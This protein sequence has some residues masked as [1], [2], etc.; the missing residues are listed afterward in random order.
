[1]EEEDPDTRMDELEQE[2]EDLRETLFDRMRHVS[3]LEHK[4]A[5]TEQNIAVLRSAL[6]QYETVITEIQGWNS[7]MSE[8]KETILAA[9]KKIQDLSE[10]LRLLLEQAECRCK[11][12]SDLRL[13]DEL[14]NLKVSDAVPD[15]VNIT[16]SEIESVLSSNIPPVVVADHP[17]RP[18]RKWLYSGVALAV[19]ILSSPFVLGALHGWIS[20]YYALPEPAFYQPMSQTFT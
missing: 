4:I 11:Q 7:A 15:N 14:D 5:S 9:Q 3:D 19:G 8:Q 10:T 13:K 1:M 2:L 18:N 16:D 17:R 20:S 6:T 12:Y